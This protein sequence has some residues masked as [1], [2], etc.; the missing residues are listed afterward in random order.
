[1]LDIYHSSA[2]YQRNTVT[3]TEMLAYSLCSFQVHRSSPFDSDDHRQWCRLSWAK[4][5]SAKEILQLPYLL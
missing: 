1:M 5:H 3:Q 2:S 4:C